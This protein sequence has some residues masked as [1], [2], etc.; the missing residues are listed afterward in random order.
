MLRRIII[1]GSYGDGRRTGIRHVSIVF[2]HNIHMHS[3]LH[4]TLEVFSRVHTLF[5]FMQSEQK[6]WV[7][8]FSR[9]RQL[10]SPTFFWHTIDITRNTLKL[11]SVHRVAGTRSRVWFCSV[12]FPLESDRG[13]TSHTSLQCL[14][15]FGLSCDFGLH[16]CQASTEH[17]TPSANRHDS[18]LQ[19]LGQCIVLGLAS[20]TSSKHNGRSKGSPCSSQMNSRMVLLTAAATTTAAGL[21]W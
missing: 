13:L 11:E 4:A 14:G 6:R 12:T 8:I 19:I 16:V 9:V 10:A 2:T 17:N 5:S 18:F 7:D 20:S 15:F 1:G 3:A 21:G